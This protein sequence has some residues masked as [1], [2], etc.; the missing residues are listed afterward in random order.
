LPGAIPGP[1]S[2]LPL[3]EVKKKEHQYFHVSFFDFFDFAVKIL[4]WKAWLA[5]GACARDWSGKPTGFA[6]ANPRTCSGKPG[7][8]GRAK[9]V[10]KKAPKIVFILKIAGSPL[11]IFCGADYLLRQ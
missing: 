7:F 9:P 3:E 10:Q 11:D 5:A 4:I 8:F 6:L 1:G 2:E